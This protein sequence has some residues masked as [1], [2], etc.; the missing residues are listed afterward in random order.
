MYTGN[1]K[2]DFRS[3]MGEEIY[4]SGDWFTGRFVLGLRHGYGV[5]YWAQNSETYIGKYYK[6]QKHGKGVLFN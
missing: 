1:F 6:S 4:P 3:G 5:Y 2:K